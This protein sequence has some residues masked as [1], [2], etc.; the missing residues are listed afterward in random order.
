MYFESMTSE[1]LNPEG[2]KEELEEAELISIN[3]SIEEFIF[4]DFFGSKYLRL[5]IQDRIG[6]KY[7]AF[8]L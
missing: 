1:L 8:N 4:A 5:S 6:M 3:I 2:F 7:Y